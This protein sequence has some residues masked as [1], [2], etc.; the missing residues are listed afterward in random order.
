MGEG[1]KVNMFEEITLLSPGPPQPLSPLNRQSVRHTKIAVT[2][3][4]C[5]KMT[6]YHHVK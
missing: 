1:F 6:V 3:Q 2:K 5:D 4:P